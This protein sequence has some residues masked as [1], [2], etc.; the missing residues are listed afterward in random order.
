MNGSGIVLRV[1]KVQNISP[2]AFLPFLPLR[3]TGMSNFAVALS[4]MLLFYSSTEL[5][6]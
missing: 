6:C 2:F 3:F 4:K 5:T 1:M